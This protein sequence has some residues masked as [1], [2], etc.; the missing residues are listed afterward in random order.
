MIN[1]L[2]LCI[3]HLEEPAKRRRH[4]AKHILVFS[5]V[6]RKSIKFRTELR[7]KHIMFIHAAGHVTT[8]L[9]FCIKPIEIMNFTHEW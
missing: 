2:I 1:I 7:M 3:L 5:N 6:Q 9:E 4:G 8:K